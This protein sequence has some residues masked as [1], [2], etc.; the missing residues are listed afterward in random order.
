MLILVGF[1]VCGSFSIS[2]DS[3][4]SKMVII[5]GANMSPCMHIGNKRKDIFILGKGPPD[6]LDDTMV[7]A[8]KECSIYVCIIMG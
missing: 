3:G 1:D 8:E 6:G 7:T 2:D 5:F 4:F